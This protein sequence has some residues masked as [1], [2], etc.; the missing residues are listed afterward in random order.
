MSTMI[1]CFIKNYE[2]GEYLFYLEA[3]L[4]SIITQLKVMQKVF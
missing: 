1:L 4:S 2:F 3:V